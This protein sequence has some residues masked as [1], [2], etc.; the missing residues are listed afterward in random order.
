MKL[1]QLTLLL[2]LFGLGSCTSEYQER[3]EEAK[4]LKDR[5]AMIEESNFISPNEKMR[6][7]ITSIEEEIHFLA[8][9]SGNEELF[10][11]EIFGELK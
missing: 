9:I 3:L 2:L 6:E 5:I 8:K 11:S 7:E 4:K 10:L 1:I